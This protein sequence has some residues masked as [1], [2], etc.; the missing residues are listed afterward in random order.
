MPHIY[1]T[2]TLSSSSATY[3]LSSS[4]SSSSATYTLSL[5]RRPYQSFIICPT[6]R[7]PLVFLANAGTKPYKSVRLRILT[8]E[9]FSGSININKKRLRE[10]SQSLSFFGKLKLQV[11]SVRLILQ[12]KAGLCQGLFLLFF[13][14]FQKNQRA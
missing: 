9:T 7:C 1:A 5:L 14:N 11:P 12:G 8:Q 4:L 6:C 2:Y 3:I 13:K 10:N